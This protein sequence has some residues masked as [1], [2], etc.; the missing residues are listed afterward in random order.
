[1]II[2]LSALISTQSLSQ[3][4]IDL[5]YKQIPLIER[6]VFSNN[7]IMVKVD[8]TFA[9]EFLKTDIFFAEY[10]ES[11]DLSQLDETVLSIPFIMAVIPIVWASD[12]SWFIES[13]DQDLYHSLLNIKKVFKLF[14]PSM[15]WDGELVPQRLVKNRP[16]KQPDG[17]AT[18]VA[19]L[20]SGGLDAVC[21]SIDHHDK[22]QLLIT[23]CGSDIRIHKKHMWTCVQQDVC[24]YAQ[25]YG[26]QN[27]FVRSNFGLLSSRRLS[28]L[29][30]QIRKWWACTSQALGYTGL[31]APICFCTGNRRLLI[32]STRTRECPFPYGTHPLI[33]NAISY[34]GI[35]ITH[36][37]ADYD[38]LKKIEVIVERCKQ[39]S[40]SLP[41]LRVCWGHHEDGGNCCRCEKCLR[42][43]NELLAVGADPQQLGFDC[44]ADKMMDITRAYL[45]NRKHF[46][47]G[48]AW[49]WG[50]IQNYVIKPEHQILYDELTKNYFSWLATMPIS[51]CSSVSFSN[52]EQSFFANLWDASMNGTLDYA[53]L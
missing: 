28:K 15:A 20:F 31:A 10:D 50:C 34:A 47:L 30:P 21:S 7:N 18:D 37:G 25:Q 39:Y 16:V 13:M 41:T 46:S 29:T 36:D 43:M 26:H 42:T 27:A 22:R 49:H 45:K 8:T 51:A 33:D 12:R 19:L 35:T 11:I 38:R 2:S 53:L 6:L 1:M 48:L 24:N 5:P 4:E 3:H 52:Q 44:S 40:M 14:Y 32:A 17:C 23:V 9:Q